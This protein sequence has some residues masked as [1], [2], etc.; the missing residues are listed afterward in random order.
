MKSTIRRGFVILAGVLAAGTIGTALPA[1][2][3]A[4]SPSPAPVTFQLPTGQWFGTP[5]ATQL[6]AVVDTPDQAG[7]VCKVKLVTRNDRTAADGTAVS[8]IGVGYTITASDVEADGQTRTV[9][10]DRVTVGPH[11]RAYFTLGSATSISLRAG[12][13]VLSGC[14]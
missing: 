9:E 1:Q 12:R 11:V 14:R 7:K 6:F 3:H 4:A 2:A 10:A 5:G 13:I 8:L